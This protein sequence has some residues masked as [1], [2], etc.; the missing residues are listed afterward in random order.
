[1]WALV[2]E[3]NQLASGLVVPEKNRCEMIQNCWVPRLPTPFQHL[4][5]TNREEERRKRE[6]ERVQLQMPLSQQTHR[7][8]IHGVVI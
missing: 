4:G 8:R 5:R 7:V 3:S 1:M 6:R 2:N